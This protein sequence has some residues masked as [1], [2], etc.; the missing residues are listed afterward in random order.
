METLSVNWWAVI[1]AAIAKFVLGAAW[2]MSPVG[3]QWQ[4]AVGL[5]DAK[6]RSGMAPALIVDIIANLVMAYVLARFVI[7]AGAGTIGSGALI[8]FMAWLGF[9]AVV[10][11]SNNTYEQRPFK[12]FIINN[13]YLLV[14]LA[15][16]GAILAAWH[17]VPVEAPPAAPAA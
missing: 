5:D 14:S 4:E 17:G 11:I 10:T 12:L 2:Y 15:V 6:A 7:W 16:M 13:I 8:G 9:V 3:K 1:V